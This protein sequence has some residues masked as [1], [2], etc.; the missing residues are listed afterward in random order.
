MNLMKPKTERPIEKIKETLESQIFQT[1]AVS[2]AASIGW[3][4]TKVRF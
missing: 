4:I 1:V 3:L 2:F